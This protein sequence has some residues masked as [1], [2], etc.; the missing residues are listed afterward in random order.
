M[1]YSCF[2]KETYFMS[3]KKIAVFAT[4]WGTDILA[5]FMRGMTAVLK[6]LNIDI[7]LFMCYASYGETDNSRYGELNIMNLPDMH[8]FDGAV[9]ITNLLDFPCE[10][11]KIVKRCHEAGIPVV[12]HGLELEGAHSVITDNTSGMETLVRH[13]IDDHGVKKFTFI[14]GN[15]DNGDSNER[16]DVLRNVCKEKNIAFSDDDIL[17]TN[18]DLS[19]A[20]NRVMKDAKEGN[21]SDAYVCANDELAMVSVIGLN[22]C[23]LECPDAA[24]VTGFD[25]VELGK[26]FYPSI[27]SVDQ[28]SEK[29]GKICAELINDL[30]NGKEADQL[31]QIP[32]TFMPSESCGCKSKQEIID[33]RLRASTI[34]FRSNQI[35]SF[36]TWHTIYIERVILNCE[37]FSE[38][39]Q[40]LTKAI[41]DDSGFEGDNFH[42]LFDPDS[43]EYEL[44]KSGSLDYDPYSEKQDVIYS[45]RNGKLQ[46]IR[47]IKTTNLIPGLEDSDPFHMYVFV[48]LH[49]REMKVG[50][51]IFTDCYDQIESA[52]IREY[53]DRFNSSIEKARKAMYLR[54][55]NDSIRE[56]SHIDA[57]THVKNRAAYELQLEEFRKKAEAKNRKF[58]FGVVL[59]DVNNLKKINDE[60]G[61]YSGDEY[62]KNAC[63]LIC[64]TYKNSPVYRIGGDEFVALL[65]GKV[66]AHKDELMETFISKMNKLRN[67]TELPPEEK[68]SVAYGMA[69][70]S[71]PSESV[72]DVIKEADERMYETKKKMKSGQL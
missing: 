40:A 66:L 39:K 16:L 1:M 70:M 37:S 23:G 42:I 32:C 51:I 11:D 71:D 35:Q 60:L 31:I 41:T 57:L 50:Y 45:V 21:L 53:A 22:D 47:S 54:T 4:G 27:A 8:T 36:A 49:E 2:S 26:V 33:K 62:I 56:L 28:N 10:A 18:W 25:Y 52:A 59:F 5:H 64:T 9:I 61:H 19:T 48:P 55:L 13:L 7:Y 43:Y 6:P 30:V 15:A 65:D 3:K 68:V 24:I 67:S 72:D 17:Y 20:Q 34:S 46:T 29:H 69:Y 58:A 14:A 38:I 12:S 63:K 44:K